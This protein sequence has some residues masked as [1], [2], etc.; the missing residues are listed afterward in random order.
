MVWVDFLALWCFTGLVCWCDL[1]WVIDVGV[2]GLVSWVPGCSLFARR[3]RCLV[4]S[5]VTVDNVG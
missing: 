1:V 4:G 3:V 2:C 5:G